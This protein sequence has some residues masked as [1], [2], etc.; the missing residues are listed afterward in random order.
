MFKQMTI[1]ELNSE[2]EVRKFVRLAHE[3]LALVNM[4][5]AE[6]GFQKRDSIRAQ[7]SYTIETQAGFTPFLQDLAK[8]E[9]FEGGTK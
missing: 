6:P 1:G 5:P 3:H 9:D 2:T 7:A 8:P 4:K